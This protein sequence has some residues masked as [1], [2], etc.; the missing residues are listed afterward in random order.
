MSKHSFHDTHAEMANYSASRP[1]EANLS[2]SPTRISAPSPVAVGAETFRRIFGDSKP[3]DISRKISACAACRKQKIK[4]HMRNSEPPCIRCKKRGLPCTVNR[5]LQMLLESDE[6]WKDQLGRKMQRMEAAMKMLAEKLAMPELLLFVEDENGDIIDQETAGDCRGVDASINSVNIGNESKN[7]LAAKFPDITPAS[8]PASCLPEITEK[9]SAGIL[10]ADTGTEMDLVTR[11]IVSIREAEDL[12]N[13]YHDQLDHYVYRI[14]PNHSTLASVRKGSPL[15]TAAICTVSSLHHR[16]L[17]PLFDCCYK[18]FVRLCAINAFSSRNTLDDIRALCIGAFWLD[19][20]SWI[21]VGIAVRIAAEKQLHRAFMRITDDDPTYYLQARLY[22]LVYVCDHHFSI[23]YGRTPMTGEYEA[24]HATSSL[25]GFA[26]ATEDDAR[27]ISQV[28]LWSTASQI[29]STFGTNISL[30]IPTNTISQLRRFNI[31]L[32]T[33]RADWNERFVHNNHVGNYPRKGVGL[34]YHFL[35]LYLC[36]HAF[37]GVL[38]APNALQALSP[39]LREIAEMAVASA[40]YILRTVNADV[41]WQGYLN[42]LPLYFD[43]MI[44]F[45]AVFLIK[46]ATEYNG[47]VK[48]DTV[49][50]LA[51]VEENMLVL[52]EVGRG[53]SANHLIS[54]IGGAI[55]VLLERRKTAREISLD[56]DRASDGEAGDTAVQTLYT[57]DYAMADEFDWVNGTFAGSA[58]QG[59]DLL[60][61]HNMPSGFEDWTFGVE[62]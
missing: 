16:S 5:S 31:S 33:W 57:Q 1:Q 52:Q 11:G 7:R 12:F 44:A 15:L 61:P 26:D 51:L 38:K 32:D 30:P 62:D 4:C 19:E 8:V 23:P 21:L 42:G 28:D 34:H 56:E 3:P 18:E 29:F 25:L 36:S 2:H 17:R 10:A 45:A 48:V 14:F 54:R 55:K 59:Y 27:L 49:G 43:T 47:T 39:E 60:S 6:V 9:S 41:E 58:L 50:L 46:T 13:M 20:I 37:R 53:M 22:Y 35:K 40:T 24:I